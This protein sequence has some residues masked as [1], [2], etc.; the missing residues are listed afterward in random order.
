MEL[1]NAGLENP[2]DVNG[3]E[4]QDACGKMIFEFQ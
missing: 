2:D 1:D 4:L 3:I